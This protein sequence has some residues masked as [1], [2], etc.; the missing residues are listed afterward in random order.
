LQHERDIVCAGFA[1]R[2]L[3]FAQGLGRDVGDHGVI[4]QADAQGDARLALG[5]RDGEQLVCV[6]C[7]GDA[8]R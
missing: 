5:R 6:E 3:R 8:L 2:C 4:G 7:S 1:D